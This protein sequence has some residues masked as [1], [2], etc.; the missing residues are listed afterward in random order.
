MTK[1]QTSLEIH[2]NNPERLQALRA[3]ALLDTPAEEAF[4]RFSRLAARFTKSPVALISL[5][6]SDRQNFKSCIGLPEPL[7]T[8]RE[9]PLSHSFC[10]H[11]R[12]AEQPLIISDARTNPQ[13][14]DNL[15]VRDFKAIA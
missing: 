2:L 6:D 15:A 8:L 4:D 12:K 7:N 14:K 10:Q 9:T 13:F 11:N 3:T 1:K 5:I